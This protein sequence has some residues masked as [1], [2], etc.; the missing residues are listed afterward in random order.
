MK[1]RKYFLYSCDARYYHAL[2]FGKS[3][4]YTY[5]SLEKLAGSVM[6]ESKIKGV[7]AHGRPRGNWIDN[8]RE[9]TNLKVD[10]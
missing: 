7:K 9:W 6:S 10:G 8:N 4:L 5:A 2:N 1:R 3:W